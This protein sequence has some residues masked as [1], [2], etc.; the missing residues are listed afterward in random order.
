M[1]AVPS[2][3]QT[4][5]TPGARPIGVTSPAAAADN[6]RRMFDTI[7]PTYDR[8]NHLLSFGL[9][10]TWWFRAARALRPILQRPEAVV[11]DLCCGTG[12]MTLALYRHRP[13]WNAS[14]GAPSLAASSSRV[15]SNPSDQPAPILAA[16]FSHNMLSLALPKFAGKNIVPME[17][18][19]LRLPL[20]DSSVDLV[21]FAF[22]FRNLSSYPAGLRELH[23]VLRPN[24][25]IAIL[26]CNQPEG[27]VGSLYNLYFQRVL[28]TVGAWIS[29]DRAAYDYLPHSVARFPQPP[30]MKQLILEAG[31][32]DPTWT[33]YTFGTAGLY[34]ATRA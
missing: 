5:P 9:D 15:G 14:S 33:S 6:I 34:R 20:A 3:L 27:F 4:E 11:L 21:T 31:F 23:R 19:A 18:D 26:E 28:P 29:R 2:N 1:D 32:A 17:A 13:K 12:D 30:K 22:G 25:Q 7:A 10:R 16:D 8:A 24:G